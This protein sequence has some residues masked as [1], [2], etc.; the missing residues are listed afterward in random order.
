MV[1]YPRRSMAYPAVQK[2][3]Q[4]K[5]AFARKLKA[6]MTPAETALWER[7]QYVA[8]WSTQVVLFGWIVDFYHQG[9]RI[10]VEIDGAYHTTPEQIQRDN[11]KDRSLFHHGIRVIRFV[12][13]EVTDD[14]R[15]II[16]K[17]QIL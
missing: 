7:L 10:A 8:G 3:Y 14:P 13:K 6:K 15:A 12:N 9:K 11:I 5:L 17:L 4:R 1:R 16:S 2:R